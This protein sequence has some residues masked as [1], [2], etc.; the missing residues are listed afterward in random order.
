[1]DGVVRG[2]RWRVAGPVSVAAGVVAGVILVASVD[3]HEP[4]H[5]PTCPALALTG[6]YC[7][8]CGG[9]RMTNSLAHGDL[10]AAFGS[11]PLLVLLLPLAVYLWGRWTWASARGERLRDPLLRPVV[12]GVL[13]VVFVVYWIVRNLPFGH[14]LAP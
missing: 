9:L 14:A 1:M 6:W 2:S 13:A 3:P 4:G 8:G 12:G 10:G 5:Y 7:P 11:N